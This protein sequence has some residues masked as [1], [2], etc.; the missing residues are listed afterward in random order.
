MA[1]WP[2]E[3]A[4]VSAVCPSRCGVLR[5]LTPA[6]RRRRAMSSRPCLEARKSWVGG[7]SAELSVTSWDMV[8]CSSLSSWYDLIWGDC[9]WRWL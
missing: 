5:G 9:C 8:G 7:S 2:E 4:M 1:S 6:W 3:Q